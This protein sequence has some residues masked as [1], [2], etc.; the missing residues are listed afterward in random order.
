M[1][2]KS[3]QAVMMKQLA[4]RVPVIFNKKIIKNL[5]ENDKLSFENAAELTDEIEVNAEKNLNKVDGAT[6][7]E[8]QKKDVINEF[9]KDVKLETLLAAVEE[10]NNALI[11]EY[12]TITEKRDNVIKK[13]EE[14]YGEDFNTMINNISS[15]LKESKDNSK[16]AISAFLEKIKNSNITN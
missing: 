15:S 8:I 3:I 6:I 10:D 2:S 11:T 14:L 4:K 7:E 1:N 5:V 9:L 12:I 13:I 16:T